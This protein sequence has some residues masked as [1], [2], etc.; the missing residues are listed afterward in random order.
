MQKG[1]IVWIEDDAE[2]IF[3]VIER[4]MKDG[5]EVVII[6]TLSEARAR[7]AEIRAAT[8]LI[9]DLIVPGNKADTA[10]KYPGLSFLR[11]LRTE[12]DFQVPVV[13]LSVVDNKRVERELVELGA[14]SMCRKPVLPSTLQ[15]AVMTSLGLPS[16]HEE[17]TI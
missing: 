13:I 10:K 7:L 2:I 15:T 16:P 14:C 6:P 17:R 8:I 11:E 4:L 9:L 12:H 5:F 1:K 3:P